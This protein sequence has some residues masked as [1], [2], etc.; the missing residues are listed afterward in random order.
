MPF[1]LLYNIFSELKELHIYVSFPLHAC[2]FLSTIW[3]ELP[4]LDG[5][6]RV[7]HFFVLLSWHI[8]YANLCTHKHTHSISVLCLKLIKW[9]RDI[10]RRYWD[11]GTKHCFS[12]RGN[13]MYIPF[14][15]ASSKF[16]YTNKFVYYYSTRGLIL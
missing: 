11:I 12:E 4:S 9:F 16:I 15:C 10:K 8:L 7:E 3:F 5:T 2:S 14:L 6:G 13:N 1:L